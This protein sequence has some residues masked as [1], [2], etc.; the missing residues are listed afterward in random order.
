MDS[1]TEWS[2]HYYQCECEACMNDEKDGDI[3]EKI[4]S[5]F[6]KVLNVQENG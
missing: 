1:K 6:K 5:F 2:E 4:L 3:V